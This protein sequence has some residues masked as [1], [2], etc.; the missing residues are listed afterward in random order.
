MKL[1]PLKLKHYH[2]T[3]LSVLARP[4]LSLDDLE[5]EGPYPV[6]DE[7]V[8]F[9]TEIE[10]G[11]PEGDNNPV[12][13][14]LRLTVSGEPLA[15]SPFPYRFAVGIEGVFVIEGEDDVEKRKKLV[16]INGGALLYGAIRDQLMTTTARHTYGA[17]LLPS[18]DFRGLVPESESAQ[19]PETK[20]AKSRK[21]QPASVNSD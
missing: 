2:F 19:R 21:K 16:V 8:D 18:L 7:R 9:N 4:D 15:D 6:F 1:S 10:L 20:K 3:A 14:A 5:Q 17:M 11:E 12:Q 13:F